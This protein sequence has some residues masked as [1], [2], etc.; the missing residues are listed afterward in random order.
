MTSAAPVREN[1]DRLACILS[2]PDDAATRADVEDLAVSA[3][4]E[5][6]TR[7]WKAWARWTDRGLQLW[8][9]HSSRGELRAFI[10]S[11]S[12]TAP[13]YGARLSML[14]EE[15]PMAIY[16]IVRSPVPWGTV[17]HARLTR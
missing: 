3:C 2:C 14:D 9:E 10:D 12:E 4:D 15:P 8:L 1:T 11:L 7:G 17:I 5:A 16:D 6:R 13:R